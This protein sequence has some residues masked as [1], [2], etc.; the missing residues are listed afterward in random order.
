MLFDQEVTPL[1]FIAEFWTPNAPV[2][3]IE[4]HCRPRPAGRL[5]APDCVIRFRCHTALPFIVSGE[6]CALMR[7]PHLR[8]KQ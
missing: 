6:I 7:V 2:S 4:E 5:D 8:I 3:E 1:T